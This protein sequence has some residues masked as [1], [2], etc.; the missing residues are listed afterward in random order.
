K[1]MVLKYSYQLRSRIHQRCLMKL[2]LNV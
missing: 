1:P 2:K